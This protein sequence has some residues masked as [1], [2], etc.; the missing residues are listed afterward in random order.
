MA[1]EGGKTD[2][3]TLK[4]LWRARAEKNRPAFAKSYGGRGRKKTDPPTLKKLWRARAKNR[5]TFAEKAMAGE[6]GARN[7]LL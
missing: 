6:G 3:P 5:L 2:P 1:G 7:S 4:K